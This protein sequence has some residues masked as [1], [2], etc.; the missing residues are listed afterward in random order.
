MLAWKEC[1]RPL[2][3]M[4]PNTSS[5]SALDRPVEA[6]VREDMMDCR[7]EGE[8]VGVTSSFRGEGMFGLVGLVIVN[9]FRADILRTKERLPLSDGRPLRSPVEGN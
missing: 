2:G 4:S 1:G 5:V 3:V 9:M 6:V 7:F 8:G